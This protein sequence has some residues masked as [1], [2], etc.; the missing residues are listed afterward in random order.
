MAAFKRRKNVI[1]AGHT[2]VTG[3]TKV[4]VTGSNQIQRD[5]VW[6][7]LLRLSNADVKIFDESTYMEESLQRIIVKTCLIHY[8]QLYRQSS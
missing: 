2:F 3:I 4:T 5:V 8:M 6:T 7:L 1:R